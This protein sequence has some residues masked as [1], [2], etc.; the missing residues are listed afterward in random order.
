MK[1]NRYDPPGEA[2]L[3]AAYRQAVGDAPLAEL[4]HEIPWKLGFYLWPDGKERNFPPPKNLDGCAVAQNQDICPGDECCTNG[5]GLIIVTA[6]IHPDHRRAVI[7][8][9]TALTKG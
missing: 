5:R 3:R 4:H 7:D 1:R 8:K 9:M 2:A 6:R